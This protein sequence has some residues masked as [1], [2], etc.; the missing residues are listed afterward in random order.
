MQDVDDPRQ[1]PAQR[2]SGPAHA[3]APGA[4]F[5][6]PARPQRVAVI[7]AGITGLATAFRLERAHPAWEVVVFEAEPRVGGKARTT[8]RDGYTVDWGPNGFLASAPET[9]ELVRELDLDEALQPAADSARRR[10]LYRDGGLRPLPASPPAFLAS[11][12][13]PLRGRLR[14]ALE[15]VLAHSAS[16][17]ESVHAF[18]A[19]HFGG[20]F[21]DALADAFVSGIT[22]GDAR[23]LSVDA[24]FPRLRALEREH[25][26]LVRGLIAQ[27]RAAR[28]DRAARAAD[29]PRPGPAAPSGRLT[30]FRGGGMQ[31]LADALHAALAGEVRV[32][33]RVAGLEPLGDGRG[34]R[35]RLAGGA[36]PRPSR[37]GAAGR[38]EP[39][40]GGASG[41]ASGGADGPPAETFDDAFDDVV[42][43]VPANAAAALL[44]AHLPAA[45]EAL[46]AIP[47]AGVRVFGLGFDRIDVPRA[48]DGFGFLVPRGQGVRSLGVLWTSSLYPERAP[49][50]KVLLRVLAGGRLDPAMLELDDAA[51][52]ASVR[53]DL[54]LS[55]GITV[56][57]A[58]VE[59]VRWPRAIPQYT[60]GHAERLR[61]IEGA[62]EALP[63][64][65]LAG[66]AYR[67]VGVNDCVREAVRVAGLLSGE[68]A[69]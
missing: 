38:T 47:Y 25:K 64:V 16:G 17:E 31:R 6:Q 22:A 14:A 50:G 19:R 28:R 65:H 9:L 13:V 35:L 46:A 12:V 5:R 29:A 42:L 26:S 41:G 58:F 66:N 32:G 3:P 21:A 43:T 57:P 8:V 62:L 60:L 34:Y 53:R 1:E 51:A 23:E 67:G 33:T 54:R 20:V 40:T 55:M 48:L 45:A 10:Y 52:L 49:A 44:K 4:P 56:E 30:S 7:G 59:A 68:G 61:T 27:Q 18:L 39:E 69:T 63:G 11:E 37:S 2:P 15:V 36:P 24:L